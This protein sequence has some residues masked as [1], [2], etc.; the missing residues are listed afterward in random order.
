M[1]NNLHPTVQA[2]KEFI[3]ERPKLIEEVRKNGRSWQEYYEKWALLGEDDPFWEEFG[4]IDTAAPNK[5]KSKQMELFNQFLKY[6]ENVDLNKVQEQVLQ[7]NKTIDTVQEVIGH[8]QETKQQTST[9]EN[10]PFNW[11]MD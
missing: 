9:K 10:E 5:T 2:F 11:F 8:F 6:T 3:N 4:D 1:E 7:L